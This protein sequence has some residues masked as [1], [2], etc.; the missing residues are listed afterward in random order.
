MVWP[1]PLHPLCPL[2]IVQY[3]LSFSY[4]STLKAINWRK[5]FLVGNCCVSQTILLQISLYRK[6]VKK[7]LFVEKNYSAILKSYTMYMYHLPT[8]IFY[9]FS[10]HKPTLK[11]KENETKQKTHQNTNISSQCILDQLT[12]PT[13]M[14]KMKQNNNKN[15]LKTQLFLHKP[16]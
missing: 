9:V 5:L 7:P 10:M 13:F 4:T 11:F 2:M 3:S 1:T 8:C 12:K 14:K 15:A 16:P 6:L